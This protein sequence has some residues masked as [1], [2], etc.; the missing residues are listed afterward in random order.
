MRPRA[1]LLAF[2][3]L[4]TLDSRL[5][6]G[7]QLPPAKK[8]PLIPTQVTQGSAGC[9]TTEASSCAQAAAKI[10][11]IV[12]GASPLEENLRRLT[13]EVGGRV[14][15]TP[16]MAKAVE[17]G[18]GA[19]RA[20]GVD[21]HAEKYTLPVMW[22]EGDTQLE[23]LGPLKFPVRL[24][25]EGW[26]PPTPAGGIEANVIDVGYGNENDFAK[27]GGVVKGAILLVHSDIGSTWADLFS[28][29]LRPPMIIDRAVR[30]GVAAI[31]WM[32]ARERL[33][34]YRHTNSLAGEIDKIP[35]AMIAR[36]DALRLART[37]A[38]YPG[39]VRVR[40]H[41]PNKIGG[42]IEQEN[43]VGEIRGYEKP[44]EIVILGAHLDSWELGTGALDN[45][46]NAALVIEAARVIKATG[47][48]PRRTIRFVLFSGEEQGTVGSFEYVKAHRTELDKVRA[49][50]T[51]DAGIGRVTG[52]SL[53]GRHDI[54]AGVREVLKPL[55]SWGA[56]NHTYDASFGTDNFDFLL[57]G[58]PTLV[59]NQEE[60]N[61]LPNYHAASDTM[62][63][64]DIRELKLHTA[65][66]ALT[67][68]G[69]ADRAEPLGKR[70]TRAE[71]VVLVKET[72]LDQQLKVLGYWNAWQSGKRGRKP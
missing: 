43:V 54:E 12:M 36:E 28:E 31:L 35:Q 48:L 24:K 4:C 32:G 19:F 38:A 70:L 26:S 64:V 33:L 65:L 3:F 15:G 34:L 29:Y 8:D 39:K 37:I 42:P 72:G 71:L 1:I 59:A 21:V 40:F 56:N 49:M 61:Y 11:P 9:S 25:A 58:V 67:A 16:E 44:D 57:E 62:D 14:T 30:E 17:W 22:S 6:A 23:T 2:L 47:L 46:C 5:P 53:G 60:A 7:A 66:A 41:M 63:K 18:V 45:G 55:E 68:W 10:L 13:D 50:I 20:A 52:Y 69:I 51:F 27:A